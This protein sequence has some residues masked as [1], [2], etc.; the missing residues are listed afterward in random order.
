MSD[1]DTFKSFSTSNGNYGSPSFLESNSLVAKFA[2]IL[3]DFYDS[4]NMKI[5]YCRDRFGI[6]P[7]FSFTDET[8]FYFSSE[9]KGLP[10]HGLG[11][12][13]EPRKVFS[14]NITYKKRVSN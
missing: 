10:F 11:H 7:L 12:Q 13:V 5:Y 2:F 1:S 3:L 14:F 6:R 9:L 4:E 8:G